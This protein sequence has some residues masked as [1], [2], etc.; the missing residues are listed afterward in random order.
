MTYINKIVRTNMIKVQP[1]DI[2]YVNQTWPLV[3]TYIATALEKGYPYPQ[4]GLLYNLE[5]VKG[6]VASGQWL[7]IVATDELNNIKGAATIEFANYPNHRVAFVT[8]IG[9]KLIVCKDTMH[10]FKSLLKQ[11]G[12]T[13]I[14]AYGRESIVRLWKRYNFEP[15]TTMVEM[16]L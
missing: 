6:Y 9:G 13:M 7:L 1:V 11:R 2:S 10:Q 16:L 5:H 14:Q 4:E 3:E 15:R 12:A 8:A